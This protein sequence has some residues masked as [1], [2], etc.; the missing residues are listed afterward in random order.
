MKFYEL[1]NQCPELLEI[2]SISKGWRKRPDRWE[3]YEKLKARV[4]RCVGWNA[5]NSPDFMQTTEA[6]DVAVKEIFG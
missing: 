3:V 5:K 6:Y 2:K 1:A 4:K